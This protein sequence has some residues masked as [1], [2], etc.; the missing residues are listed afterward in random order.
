MRIALFVETYTPCIN[1]VVTHLNILKKGFEELGHEVL[2]VTAD[3][4]TKKHYIEDGIM[5]CP[6]KKLKR[7]YGF[8]LAF[9]FSRKRLG[10]LKNFDPDIIHV[11]Q[12]FGVG[13]SGFLFAKILKVPLIYTLH[14]MYDEYVFYVAP[15]MLIKI[16]KKMLHSYEKRLASS[17]DVIVGPS[18]KVED[19]LRACGVTK[20]IEVIPNTADLDL[21]TPDAISY[22]EKLSLRE[23]LG[24]PNGATIGCFVGRL[25]K[26]KSVDVVINNIAEELKDE[27]VY[28][29][30][31][32]SGPEEEALKKLSE[33]LSLSDKIR[34]TGAVEH[35]EVSRY[36]SMCDFFITA[37]L[38][39]M[40]S[41]SM[42]EAMSSGLPIIARY[43]EVNASQI[44]SGVNGEYFTNA[45]E[46]KKAIMK[47]HRLGENERKK[48]K[49]NVRHTVESSGAKELAEY[50][51]TFYDREKEQKD[52]KRKCERG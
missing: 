16:T 1:G 26:E 20:K 9:P 5:H 8:G 37:S 28:F 46:M 50:I 43:D 39:E 32:G 19:F 42:L 49:N 30:I 2:I 34:F 17:A 27:N 47:I 15:K 40:H 33:E 22:E 23:N 7:V 38:T 14:T 52:E 12:E 45:K 25:G 24:I 13:L 3:T 44:A 36:Y 31:V 41:I 21:F 51:L 48:L 29:V 6:A 10:L 11:H 18:K 4:E 35:A